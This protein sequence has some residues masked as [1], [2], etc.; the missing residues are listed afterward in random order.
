MRDAVRPCTEF[1]PPAVSRLFV[2]AL[3][4]FRPANLRQHD[5]SKSP[6]AHLTK[7]YVEEGTRIE[8]TRPVGSPGCTGHSTGTRLHFELYRDGSPVNP[9]GFLS[10][11]S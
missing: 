4:R 7:T 5:G 3:C 8:Q 11:R 9:L 1:L 2:N 10:Q 6:Y